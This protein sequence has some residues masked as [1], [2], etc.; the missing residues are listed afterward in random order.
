VISYSIVTSDQSQEAVNSVQFSLYKSVVFDNQFDSFSFLAIC[1]SICDS[2][3]DANVI[4][5][6]VVDILVV[7]IV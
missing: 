1:D 4:V 7:D 2:I 5:I 6:V 3:C